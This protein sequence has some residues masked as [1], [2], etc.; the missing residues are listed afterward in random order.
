MATILKILILRL[1]YIIDFSNSWGIGLTMSCLKSPSLGEFISSCSLKGF[2]LS[3]WQQGVPM[4]SLCPGCGCTLEGS[5]G[6][7]CWDPN[8]LLVGALISSVS[9]TG[10][11]HCTGGYTGLDARPPLLTPAE[12]SDFSKRRG[13]R[14]KQ[15]AEPTPRALVSL[16]GKGSPLRF[17]MGSRRLLS[18]PHL[19]QA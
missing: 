6:G 8:I 7:L 13:S 3:S 4:G 19:P 18:T 15:M 14:G 9:Q 17:P 10:V 12:D 2:T 16:Q 11:L 5:H 1:F